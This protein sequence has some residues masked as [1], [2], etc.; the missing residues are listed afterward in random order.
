MSP[1][2]TLTTDAGER[3]HFESFSGWDIPPLHSVLS[4]NLRRKV[5]IDLTLSNS[6]P[7]FLS[8]KSLGVMFSE[9]AQRMQGRETGHLSK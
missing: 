9:L 2:S 7:I 8:H 5:F 1:R 4:V 3:G 6:V